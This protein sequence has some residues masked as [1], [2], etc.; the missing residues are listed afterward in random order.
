MKKKNKKKQEKEEQEQGKQEEEAAARRKKKGR[1]ILRRRSLSL[2]YLEVGVEAWIACFDSDD[3]SFES[4]W[5]IHRLS[6]LH[7]GT[8]TAQTTCVNL[9]NSQTN[10][11]SPSSTCS[12]TLI[13]FEATVEAE[14]GR[15]GEGGGEGGGT[16]QAAFFFSGNTSLAGC[17]TES[18]PVSDCV[19]NPACERIRLAKYE[20]FPSAQ[21]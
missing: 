4:G 15:R 16:L 13:S 18:P 12:S 20:L 17:R 21:T 19:S 3:I 2:S 8:R 10:T 9:T 1:R 14:G 7:Y 6:D 11:Y 5:R